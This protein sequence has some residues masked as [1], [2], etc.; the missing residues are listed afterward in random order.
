MGANDCW[1]AEILEKT[2]RSNKRTVPQS[3]LLFSKS[4]SNFLTNFNDD[5]RACLIHCEGRCIVWCATVMHCATPILV[6][7]LNCV[8]K[9]VYFDDDDDDDV[10]VFFFFTTIRIF[11]IIIVITSVSL[12]NTCSGNVLSIS[13]AIFK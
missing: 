2:T 13:R 7:T 11:I 6:S 10:D 5:D 1:M 9:W 8:V 3:M 4:M 12:K